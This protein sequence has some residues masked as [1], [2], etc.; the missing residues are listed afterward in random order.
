MTIEIPLRNR[1][2]VVVAVALIDDEDALLALL[3]WYRLRNG[4]AVRTEIV[5]STKRM[6]YM[7]R[8]ILPGWPMVDHEN[9][10]RLDNRRSNLRPAD[11]A[12]NAQNRDA[13]RG[14]SLPRGVCLDRRTGKFRAF[15]KLHGHAKELGS[16]LTAA[17]ADSA[18][19]N[20]R[21]L[22]MPYSADARMLG[23][24]S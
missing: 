24:T 23:G 2:R 13:N 8:E 3:N 5:D 4:Y 20:W 12:L 17:E 9:G 1:K 21:S 7:H 22:H 10:N 18:A 11:A 19:R 15:V 6:R 14:R 16:Y